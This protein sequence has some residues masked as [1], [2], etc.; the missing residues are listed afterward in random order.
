MRYPYVLL[1]ILMSALMSSCSSEDIQLMGLKA[2]NLIN[3]AQRDN[4]IRNWAKRIK[5]LP[6]CQLYKNNFV[7]VG[8]KHSGAASG[9]FVNDMRTIYDTASKNGCVSKDY[10]S[11]GENVGEKYNKSL[12]NNAINNYVKRISGLPRCE[13]YKN[14]YMVVGKRHASA[15]SGAFVTD[16][17]AIYNTAIEDGCI[18]EDYQTFGE[19]IGAM[20]IKSQRDNIIN[21]WVNRIS[22]LPRCQLYKNNYMVVGKRHASAA[23]GAFVNDMRAIYDQASKQGCVQEL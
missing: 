13:A 23:S 3:I 16:M 21:N 15:A 6:S 18:S 19:K 7:V 4:A 11:F 2:G 8:K 10:R 1:I 17:R 12:R 22:E 9:A 20:Y 5:D 14:N